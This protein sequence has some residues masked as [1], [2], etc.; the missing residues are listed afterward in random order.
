MIYE[1]SKIPKFS[2]VRYATRAVE[3]YNG[4][5]IKSRRHSLPLPFSDSIRRIGTYKGEYK[6]C[7]GGGGMWQQ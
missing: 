4:T 7:S 1:N 6:C 2:I 5:V 3:Y